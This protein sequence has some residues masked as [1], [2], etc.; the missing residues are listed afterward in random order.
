MAARILV[1]EDNATNLALLQYLLTSAGHVVLQARDGMAGVQVAR[2]EHPD[3]VVC[4]LQM[5]LLDGYGVLLALRTD[6]GTRDIP[7]I[8]VTAFSMSDDRDRV[9]EAGFDGYLTKPIEPEL[10]V[11]Q[12]ESYLCAR[13]PAAP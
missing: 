10:F 12:I 13:P 2:L 8:A 11:G 1:I 5:P 3:L 4:D 9:A 7:V 6:A